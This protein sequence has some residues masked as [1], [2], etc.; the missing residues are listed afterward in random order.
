M[1]CPK[2]E[3]F[4]GAVNCSHIGVEPAPLKIAHTEP[5]SPSAERT[6]LRRVAPLLENVPHFTR[7]PF[8]NSKGWLRPHWLIFGGST[9]STLESKKK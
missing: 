7:S 8:G 3:E 6:A 5:D 4:S 9:N 1:K 2:S